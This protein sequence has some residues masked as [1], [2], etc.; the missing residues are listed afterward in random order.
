MRND[1]SKKR[2]ASELDQAIPPTA[3]ANPTEAD[4]LRWI[5]AAFEKAT[6]EL[7]KTKLKYT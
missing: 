7:M 5:V 1:L 3:P 6:A 4:S 2:I